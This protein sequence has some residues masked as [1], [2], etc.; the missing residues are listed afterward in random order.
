MLGA[1]RIAPEMYKRIRV[2]FGVGSQSGAFVNKSCKTG[3]DRRC[4]DEDGSIRRKRGDTLVATLR[5]EYGDD[6][7]RGVR[8]DK[9]LDSLLEEA[10][11]N[12]LSEYL[13]RR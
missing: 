6:F 13:R 10:G 3:L 11:A 12:S 1:S 5:H 4:R 2:G 8:S 7:A 9:R